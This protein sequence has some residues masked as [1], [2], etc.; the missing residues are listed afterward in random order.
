M[1]LFSTHP[2]LFR[3]TIVHPWLVLR[4]VR[5][6]VRASTTPATAQRSAGAGT[7]SSGESLSTKRSGRGC[8]GGSRKRGMALPTKRL[9]HAAAKRRPSEDQLSCSIVRAS[10]D[11][12]WI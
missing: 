12:L 9:A 10:V 5:P 8:S 4:E 11:A 1:G 7:A 3:H 6:A 2:W